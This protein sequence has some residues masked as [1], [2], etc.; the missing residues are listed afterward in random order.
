MSSLLCLVSFALVTGGE[1]V[2]TRDF[3]W[4]TCHFFGTSADSLDDLS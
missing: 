3:V 2:R 1:F 4:F